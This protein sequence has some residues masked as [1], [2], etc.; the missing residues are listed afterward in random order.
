MRKKLDIIGMEFKY[1]KVV[2]YFG[3]NKWNQLLYKCIC[4]CG[5]ETI[6]SVAALRSGNTKSCGCYNTESRKVN[7]SKRITHGFTSKT[8]KRNRIYRIWG[9]MRGRCA[10]SKCVNWN[11]RNIIVCDEWNDFLTFYNWANS[12]GYENGLS[13]DRIDNNGNYE[14]SNCRWTTQKIQSNNRRNS[15][16]ITHNGETKTLAQWMD[17]YTNVKYATVNK[18]LKS[19]KTFEQAIIPV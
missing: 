9:S 17:I 18:R 11:G 7:G 1:L 19:G 5:K 16:Y 3:K 14:P 6:S 13:I 8:D 10:N 12:N 15:F 2:E 4:R